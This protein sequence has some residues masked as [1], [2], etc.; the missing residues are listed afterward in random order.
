[1]VTAAD[2]TAG[3]VAP[4]AASSP[5]AE[6]TATETVEPVS[7]A[8]AAEARD[9]AKPSGLNGSSAEPLAAADLE[10]AG[11]QLVESRSAPADVTDEAAP[12]RLGRSRKRRAPAAGEPLQQVET[13]DGVG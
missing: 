5:E 9:T 8:H 12:V 10:S 7:E 13:Q 6:V 4:V 1:D 3:E 11:F 2:V